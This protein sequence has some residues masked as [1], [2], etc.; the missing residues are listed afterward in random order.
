MPTPDVDV[1]EVDRLSELVVELFAA[2]RRRLERDVRLAESLHTFYG[3]AAPRVPG[4][5]AADSMRKFG[6][7]V[8]LV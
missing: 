3:P 6:E 7:R 4:S 2:K 5:L 8:R 1:S